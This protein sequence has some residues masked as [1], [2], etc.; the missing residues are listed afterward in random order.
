[1]GAPF[2]YP[3]RE[4]QLKAATGLV[5]REQS[6]LKESSSGG[7]CG[8]AWQMCDTTIADLGRAPTPAEVTDGAHAEGRSPTN[9][10]VEF[11]QWRKFRAHPRA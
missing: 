8:T 5:R 6:G 4:A 7:L 9:I 11:Y 3:A 1:M 2:L 10:R